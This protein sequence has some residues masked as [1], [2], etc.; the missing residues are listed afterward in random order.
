MRKMI[1][2]MYIYI[3]KTNKIRM[4]FVSLCFCIYYI[5]NTNMNIHICITV[6]GRVHREED[7]YGII[8]FSFT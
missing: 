7:Y 5:I 6:I 4:C 2:A 8:K 3:L 1:I